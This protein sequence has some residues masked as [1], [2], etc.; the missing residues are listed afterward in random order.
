MRTKALAIAS[1]AVALLA[2]ACGG[3]GEGNSSASGG[4]GTSSGASGGG[5]IEHPTGPDDLVLRVFTGGGFTSLEWSLREMPQISIYGDGRLIVQGP[6]I[7]IYPGPA[8]PN[9]QVS[10]LTEEGLQAV[11]AAAADAGLL[12]KDA[13]YPFACVSDLPTT[14]FTVNAGGATHTVSAYALGFG[15]ST[16]ATGASGTSGTE[17]GASGGSGVAGSS[18]TVEPSGAI[19]TSVAATGTSGSPDACGSDV[20]ARQ[21]LSAFDAKLGDLASWL[22]AGSIG[23]EEAYTPSEMRIY[24]GKYRGDPQLEQTAVAWPLAQPLASFGDVDTNG[25][26]L[27]C[28]VLGGD[29]LASLLP[30]AQGANEL[31]PW[32]SRG[33]RYSLVFRPLLPDEH[34]C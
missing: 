17:P 30:L 15:D 22:P 9:L 20:D 5:A 27:R 16:G 26:G 25:T 1:L 28:G 21:R 14:T 13:D 6:V 7:E 8:L 3:V 23:A 10:H 32:T 24:V 19:G 18:G 31:T 33:H 11:L 2:S 12:G 29:D 4:T 34:A